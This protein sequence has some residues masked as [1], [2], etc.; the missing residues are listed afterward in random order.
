DARINATLP[1]TE[2]A[3][4]AAGKRFE[5]VTYA[6]AGHGFMRSGEAPDASEANRKA[7]EDGWKRWLDLLKAM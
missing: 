1:T 4:T 3:M 2:T 5:P 7:R 6:G